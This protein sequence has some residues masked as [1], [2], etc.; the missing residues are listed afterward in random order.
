MRSNVIGHKWAVLCE[1]NSFKLDIAILLS[2][3][4]IIHPMTEN[5]TRIK[6][7]QGMSVGDLR[8][9]GTGFSLDREDL[10]KDPLSQFQQW[11]SY[12]CETVAMDPN[13]MTLTTVNDQN[14]P[15]SRTVLLKSFDHN[16]FVFY[17]NYESDKSIHI[18][19]NPNVSLLFFW[20]DAARQIRVRGLATKISREE[21]LR[22]FLSRPRGSQ[23][24]AWVSE[25]SKVIESRSVLEKRF[26]EIKE[27]FRNREIPLPD[28]WGGYCVEPIEIEFWQGRRNRLHDRFRY[29]KDTNGA[30]SV[31]RLAP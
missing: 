11:F 7:P 23:I 27:Q 29:T 1:R 2:D 21:S 9:S 4:A 15:H 19:S 12:A 3:K 22:Y 28:F 14:E 10:E 30:W 18:S 20:S 31:Q 25:Q 6:A 24:G 16:G 17:S 26:Q 8:R 5:D 13:A